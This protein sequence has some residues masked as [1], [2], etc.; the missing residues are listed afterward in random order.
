MKMLVRGGVSLGSLRT[1]RQ[2]HVYD[3]VRVQEV[4]QAPRL[5]QGG[6]RFDLGG[7]MYTRVYMCTRV[8]VHVCTCALCRTRLTSMYIHNSFSL[9]NLN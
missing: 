9:H 6:G 1:P 2:V 8:C 7:G 4:A 5:E 3:D